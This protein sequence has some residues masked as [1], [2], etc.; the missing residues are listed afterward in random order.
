MMAL[1]LIA[2]ALLGSL[3]SACSPSAGTPTEPVSPYQLLVVTSDLTPQA[4][5]LVLTLWDG[6]QRLTTAQ[7]MEVS[8]Y[9]LREQGTTGEK[10]WEGEARGYTT[11]GLQYWVLYPTLPRAGT[12]GVQ[13]LV[14]TE[15]GQQ[16]EN[17]ATLVVQPEARTPT[18]GDPAPRSDTLTLADVNSIEELAS[19]G[20]YNERFY[21]MT[22]AEAAESGKP[23]LIAF[24]TPGYCTSALCTPV[25]QS[26][27]EVSEE[28]DDSFNVVHVEVW[29]NF[30]RQERD[31]A[32]FE[33]RLQTEPWLFVLDAS[34][35]VAARLEGPVSPDELREVLAQVGG[36]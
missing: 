14:T 35:T 10:V 17:L 13:T 6:P 2:L 23:S 15:D 20:P 16:V 33:W 30:Q 21:K 24:T 27:A 19:A 22:I 18:L 7:R 36:Q 11:E 31:P 4:D 9:P 25:T 3:L 29:R 1:R 26:V 28:V 32:V 12:Y 8:I 34:G 5:R